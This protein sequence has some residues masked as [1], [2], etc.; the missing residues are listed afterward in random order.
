M[1]QH[2]K[3]LKFL[4]YIRRKEGLENMTENILKAKKNYKRQEVVEG[5]DGQRPKATRNIKEEL[6]SNNIITDNNNKKCQIYGYQF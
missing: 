4:D 6:C 5:H 1:T 2:Q 3:E